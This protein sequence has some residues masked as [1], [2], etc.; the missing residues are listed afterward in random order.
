MVLP[1]GTVVLGTI[2]MIWYFQA[3]KRPGA[4]EQRGFY[5]KEPE[6]VSIRDTVRKLSSPPLSERGAATENGMVGWQATMSLIEGATGET[7]MGYEPV[8]YEYGSGDG[9]WKHIWVDNTGQR[10]ITEIV[11]V[12]VRS[13][14]VSPGGGVVAHLPLAVGLELAHAF[15]GTRNRRTIRFLFLGPGE[16]PTG[17][18]VYAELMKDRRIKVQGVIDLDASDFHAP[19]CLDAAGQIDDAALLRE[20]ENLRQGITRLANQ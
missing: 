11:E 4:K 3:G 9:K 14:P 7:N 2:A 18:Q 19:R 17:E 6:A 8:L 15:T 1:I 12:R 13:V 16:A 5:T 20:V 10:N